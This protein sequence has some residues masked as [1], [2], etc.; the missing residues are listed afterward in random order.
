LKSREREYKEIFLAE[1]REEFDA[2]NQHLTYLEKAPG[3]E[4]L[5]GEIFRLLHNLKAN[6]KAIGYLDIAQLVHKLESVFGALRNKDLEFST[7]LA[8]VLFAAVDG[9]GYLLDNVDDT[10]A[11]PL[12]PSIEHNLEATLGGSLQHHD[13][14]IKHY[15]T[16]Q[17]ITLS[18]LIYIPIRKLDD[19]M[20]LVGE[21][22]IDRDRVL[23]I[24][25]D[26]E[27][28]RLK[29]VGA[30]LHRI[31]NEIQ[32]AVM[33]AR[34]VNIG[35]L[36]NK[37]PR[38]VRDISVIEEKPIELT[39][40]GQDIQIDRNILQV[41]TDSLLHLVRN[42][43]SHGI[44]NQQERAAAGKPEAGQINLSATSDKDTVM[45]QVSDDG[46]GID[47]GQVHRYAVA[48]R[49]VSAEK[50]DEL[51]DKELLSFIFEPGF[52]LSTKV[53]EVAGRGVGLD[54]VKNAIDTL[55]GRV[56]VESKRGQGTT[57]S[58]Y[59]PTSM[60]VKG[61]LLFEVAESYYAIP[62]IH[63][64]AVVTLPNREIH[65]VGT[66]L[67]ADIKGE[68]LPLIDLG[69]LFYKYSKEGEMQ[70]SFQPGKMLQDIVV[71]SYN[72]RKL[73]FIVDKLLRQQDIVVKPLQQPVDTIDI[74][75]GVTLLG[76]GEICLVLDV[77][78]ISRNFVLRNKEFAVMQD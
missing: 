75:G 36:F 69:E 38:I 58:L 37:F 52:S 43:V 18:D 31:A 23:A 62:L 6:A 12:D 68:T 55:G 34:L 24:A 4:K 30:H 64:D 76:G 63:T 20:N 50:A 48:N 47:V 19:L 14:N 10:G 5:L 26:S 66:A 33:D 22:I 29:A 35:F 1:A 74:F 9:L 17:Q 77:P 72:N 2:I 45:I 67:V 44:E 78:S 71:V 7:Q 49:Y 3:D 57:F 28:D 11:K 61:A 40:S 21:L 8:N 56:T 46:K 25:K 13:E 65:Q 32:Q 42:A 27:D 51:N 54:V 60:A 59:V 53:T 15:H 39:I 16:A 41:L 73:G 70:R